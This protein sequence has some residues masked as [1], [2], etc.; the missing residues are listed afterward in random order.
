[1][2][3]SI[4]VSTDRMFNLLLGTLTSAT[5]STLTPLLLSTT[6]KNASECE[7]VSTMMPLVMILPDISAQKKWDT[8]A[9][10]ILHCPQIAASNAVSTKPFF[11]GKLSEDVL[12]LR[13]AMLNFK[14]MMP[15]ESEM[16]KAARSVTGSWV[17][18]KSLK[19][20]LT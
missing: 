13:T 16:V 17:S 18:S 14:S 6:K 10:T 4:R 12:P 15:G 8:S 1:M 11:R 2:V 9:S 3:S 19:K 7:E 20:S 5:G